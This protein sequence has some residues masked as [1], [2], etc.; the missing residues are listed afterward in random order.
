MKIHVPSASTAPTR[1]AAPAKETI[2]E[3]NQGARPI[4]GKPDRLVKVN[5]GSNDK[6]FRFERR[7]TVLQS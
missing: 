2:G 5:E 1:L 3:G 6:L 4:H 7:N